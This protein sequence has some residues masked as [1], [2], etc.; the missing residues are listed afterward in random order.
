MWEPSSG[1]AVVG[2]SDAA[3]A[4][5]LSGRQHVVVAGVGGA[6]DG[7]AR[8]LDP[9]ARH[10]GGHGQAAGACASRKGLCGRVLV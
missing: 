2:A 10:R 1:V 8:P 3:T 5:L 4:K 7:K 6:G 9:G